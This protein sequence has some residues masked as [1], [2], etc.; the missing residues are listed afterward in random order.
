MPFQ[1]NKSQPPIAETG[2]V[3]QQTPEQVE[4]S[5]ETLEARVGRFEQGLDTKVAGLTGRRESA[6]AVMK[7]VSSDAKFTEGEAAQLTDLEST[8]QGEASAAKQSMRETATGASTEVKSSPERVV[9]AELQIKVQKL[10]DQAKQNLINQFGSLEAAQSYHNTHQIRDWQRQDRGEIANIMFADA[11][12]K[13]IAEGEAMAGHI[14]QGHEKHPAGRRET[15]AEA[16]GDLAQKSKRENFPNLPEAKGAA[17]ESQSKE[18]QEQRLGQVVDGLLQTYKTAYEA[19]KKTMQDLERNPMAKDY[20]YNNSKYLEAKDISM[21]YSKLERV[22]QALREGK[23]TSVGG[24]GRLEM[25]IP[26]RNVR[27]DAEQVIEGLR[28]KL[29]S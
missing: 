10:V 23:R 26:P 11:N 5:G 17:P 1:E 2:E 15:F 9:N 18:A 16:I 3:R 6:E 20:L 19:A 12:L 8:A 22:G 21:A 27:E 14:E 28:Q 13:V 29:S 24:D 4:S 25:S 7:S